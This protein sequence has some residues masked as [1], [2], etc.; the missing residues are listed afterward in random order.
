MSSQ[1]HTLVFLFCRLLPLFPLH[2][3]TFSSAFFSVLFPWVKT[4]IWVINSDSFSCTYLYICIIYQVASPSS[5]NCS[6]MNNQCLIWRFTLKFRLKLIRLLTIYTLSP[7]GIVG[8]T[9]WTT[10]S[11]LKHLTTLPAGVC[12]LPI[13]KSDD[14][15]KIFFF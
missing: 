2:P 1:P 10:H 7:Q 14:R 13:L 4:A 6:L 15:G 8:P 11:W 9:I 3:F 12:L 5:A